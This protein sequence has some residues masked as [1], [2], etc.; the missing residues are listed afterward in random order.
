MEKIITAEN[1]RPFAYLNEAV[2][3]RPIRAVAVEFMGL[4]VLNQFDE[5]TDRGRRLGEM[6]VLLV[7]PYLNPWN[8][9]NEQAVRQTDEILEAAHDRC[10]AA[11]GTP[12]VSCGGSMGGLAALV[13]TRY[14]ARRP[15]ACVANCPVCD[16]PYHYTERPD[17]PRT[18]L[19][20]FACSGEET[21]E[22]AMRARS[23]LHLAR[24]GEMPKSVR[25]TV[26]HCEEDRAVNKAMHS[27]RFAA[28]MEPFAPVEYIAVPGRGHCDLTEEMIALY[29]RR[30]AEAGQGE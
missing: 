18:L 14:A 6:G 7:I 16:L 17:L 24:A 3:T 29:E 10:G 12:L 22:A 2:C 15:A 8:W 1:L 26:F 28:A 23:P 9:M 11:E 19:S 27:D 5:D 25:Y 13:Y 30:I 21:L 4:N 20:A